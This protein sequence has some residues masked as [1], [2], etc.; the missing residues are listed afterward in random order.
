MW[1][2][3]SRTPLPFLA[4]VAQWLPSCPQPG[5]FG[6]FNLPKWPTSCHSKKSWSVWFKVCGLGEARPPEPRKAQNELP[7]AFWEPLG[8]QSPE[9]LKLS[10]ERASES[11]VATRVQNTA[12]FPGLG[13]PMCAPCGQHKKHAQNSL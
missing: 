4:L 9:Q 12:A 6:C 2:P 13:G 8:H 11:H 3:E 10:L 1:P 5:D 7:D